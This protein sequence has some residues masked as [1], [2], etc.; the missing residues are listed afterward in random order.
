[1]ICTHGHLARQCELCDRDREIAQLRA[2]SLRLLDALDR[3]DHGSREPGFR[4][5]CCKSTTCGAR[6]TQD[7]IRRAA[8]GGARWHFRMAVA[9]ALCSVDQVCIE[10]HLVNGA[11]TPD[12][13]AR[14]YRLMRS[15]PKGR[16]GSTGSAVAC[17][18][19]A[20]QRQGAH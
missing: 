12:N 19:F 10:S 14:A 20:F 18:L 16:C 1:M 15:S 3:L 5:W 6:T 8:L 11:A 2:A 7:A 9:E 13:R 4:G 17:R